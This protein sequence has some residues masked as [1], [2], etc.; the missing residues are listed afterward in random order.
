MILLGDRIDSHEAF[1]IGLVNKVVALDD[2]FDEAKSL[3]KRLAAKPMYA[4]RLAKLVMDRG[5]DAELNQGLT[6]E[7]LAFRSEEHTSELKSLM[8]I[9]Y[10]VF[11]LKKK[12]NLK[13]ITLIL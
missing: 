3:A 1:R 5:Y 7:L 9:S 13:L 2:L 10:A 12:T 8:R 6:M 4:L 11:C